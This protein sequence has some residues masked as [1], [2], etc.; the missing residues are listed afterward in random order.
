MIKQK[1]IEHK[2][3]KVED[4]IKNPIVIRNSFNYEI[5]SEKML[6]KLILEDIP[7]FL[8]ELGN[9]FC[10]ISNE[11][12]IKMGNTYNYIDLL[13]YNIEFN[14]YVVVELKVTE[15]KKEHIGQIEVYMNYIDKN[16]KTPMQNKTIGII[17]CKKDNR[18]IIEYCSDERITVR[19]Y[20][21]I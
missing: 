12:K 16:L 10:F 14:C 15:L 7:F 8:R 13:L 4:L 9:S 6:Q 21:L 19:K 17:I 2:E 5:I 1:L 3:T 20:E 11:Y 18:F